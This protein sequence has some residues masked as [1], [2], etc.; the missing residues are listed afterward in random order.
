MVDTN[1]SPAF[2]VMEQ[3]AQRDAATLIQR[4]I[5][6]ET[7]VWSDMW[8]AYNNVQYLPPGT[9]PDGESQHRVCHLSNRGPYPAHRVLLVKSGPR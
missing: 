7:I 6:P 5:R 2:G 9:T 8:A 4:H 3:V 1:V